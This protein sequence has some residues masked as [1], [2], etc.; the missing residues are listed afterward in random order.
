MCPAS[1]HQVKNTIASVMLAIVFWMPVNTARAAD[2]DYGFYSERAVMLPAGKLSVDVWNTSGAMVQRSLSRARF[3]LGRAELWA[4][5]AALGGKVKVFPG[6]ISFARMGIQSAGNSLFELGSMVGLGNTTGELAIGG[7][8]Y[9]HQ[10]SFG[11]QV[12]GLMRFRLPVVDHFGPLYLQAEGR[13]IDHIESGIFLSGG[14]RWVLHK[15]VAVDLWFVSTNMAA[16][17]LMFASPAALRV[18]LML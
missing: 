10:G 5:E 13:A 11:M 8:V 16:N 6:V 4:D 15:P 14:L 18:T 2:P 1:G 3:G 9:Q 12:N 7:A 17:D